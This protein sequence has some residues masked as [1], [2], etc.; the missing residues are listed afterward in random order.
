MDKKTTDQTKGDIYEE[1]KQ[2]ETEEEQLEQKV[3]DLENQ[4]KRVL[5]DYQNLEKRI[6][7]ERQDWVRSANRELL[8][9]ILPILDT[10]EL[11]QKHSSDETVKVCIQLFLDTLKT[12]GIEKIKTVGEKFDP[13]VME[14]VGVKEGKEGI[15]LEEARAGYLLSEKLLRPAQVIVGKNSN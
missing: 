5:A 7:D 14:G 9:R 4:V 13:G 6:R 12:E 15:V 2:V 11:A 10:L 1:E 8:L 3:H